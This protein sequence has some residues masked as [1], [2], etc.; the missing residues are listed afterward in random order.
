M[1][2]KAILLLL[3]LAL[4]CLAHEVRPAYVELTETEP[5]TFEAVWKVPARGGSP[6]AGDDIPHAA[7]PKPDDKAPR[8]TLPCGC[9]APTAADLLMGVLPIHPTLPP[10]AKLVSL[11][12]IERL[13]GAQVQ[14]WT[15]SF[16]GQGLAGREIRIHGIEAFM[17]DVLVRVSFVDGRVVSKLLRPDSPAFSVETGG[18]STERQY[19]VLGLEHIL[20]GI[21]HLL[22][23]LGLL[24]IVHGF[25]RLVKTITALTVAHSITLA[26]ATLGVVNIPGPPVEAIIALSIVFVAREALVNFTGGNGGN[27]E[28]NTSVPSVSSGSKS[29]TVRQPWLVAFAFGLLHGF[30]FA[31]A[32]SQAGLPPREIPAALLFFNVGVELGQLAF[33]GAVCG[34]AAFGKWF[35]RVFSVTT[36]S[37]TRRIAPY[38]IGGTA[39]FWL[40]AR[41]SSF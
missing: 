7:D 24:L 31:G 39:A 11:R 5:G 40:I 12:R 17:V 41:F 36:P 13:Q 32:L 9:P 8:Q 16:G 10:H 38:A 25:G 18:G 14:R 37:W 27:G 22:F 6:L 4:P 23:V 20:L 35:A 3:L 1:E 2:M 34:V 26:L 30:G 29:L 28:L 21:D 15:V 19:L 33:V